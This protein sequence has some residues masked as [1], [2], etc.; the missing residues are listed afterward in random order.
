MRC[1]A[2]GDKDF[3]KGVGIYIFIFRWRSGGDR[4]SQAK[5]SK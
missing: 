3:E 1:Q 4:W 2:A 5:G